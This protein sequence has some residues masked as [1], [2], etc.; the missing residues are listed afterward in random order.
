MKS[1]WLYPSKLNYLRIW[2]VQMITG[3]WVS[4]E[5]SLTC[6]TVWTHLKKWHRLCSKN[7]RMLE[8]CDLWCQVFDRNSIKGP[9]L[10]NWRKVAEPGSNTESLI[11]SKRFMKIW[12]SNWGFE[13]VVGNSATLD[14][15]KIYLLQITP[16]S[17]KSI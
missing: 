6:I 17:V 9:N 4:S 8:C 11:Q 2:F 15:L 10:L 7:V 3:V 5:L 16:I 12:I 13:P 1:Y 14:I